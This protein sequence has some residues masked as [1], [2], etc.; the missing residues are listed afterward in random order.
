MRIIPVQD[1]N[2]QHNICPALS[3]MFRCFVARKNDRDRLLLNV[4]SATIQ[5]TKGASIVSNNTSLFA[6][7]LKLIPRDQFNLI[8]RRHGGEKHAKGFTCYDQLV[9]MMFC[10]FTRVNSLR[11]INDGLRVTG[12]KLNHLG[13]KKAAPKSTLAYANSHRPWKIYEDLFHVILSQSVAEASGKKRKFRFKNKLY[14]MDA[15]I[16]DL[17][18]AVFPWAHFRQT[19]GAVKL[20]MLLDH[21]GYLPSFAV[22]TEGKQHEVTV[23]GDIPL[24]SGCIVA[25]DRG[26]CDYALY[27]K[28]TNEGVYFVTRQKTNAAYRVIK[29]LDVS[30]NSKLISDE[31]IVLTGP[32]SSVAY[33]GVLR[34]VC[35][36]D[37]ERDC[38]FVLLTNKMDLVGN[39]IA[40]IYKD[41]WEIELFFKCLKQNFKVKTFVG[42]TANALKIQIWT[43]LITLLL[44]KLLQ[45][46]SKAHLPICRLLSILRLN[47]FAYRD[48]NAWL[49]D[50]FDIPPDL[51][52]PVQMVLT[53]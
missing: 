53:I 18:A 41:R 22:I 3:V 10:Q 4:G 51:P 32:Q 48:L 35:V 50:P 43:A 38:D 20:H 39:T 26:Y 28:W 12:G 2:F 17:C 30:S 25:V 15:T 37:E 6:Q 7:I 47:L 42:T 34:R 27:Q 46:R 11:E 44:I 33:P 21:D 9:S 14:S 31:H 13:V 16:I 5:R 45:F 8:V 40:Q 1:N 52:E 29:S 36:R 23:A 19:K 49:E 24:P